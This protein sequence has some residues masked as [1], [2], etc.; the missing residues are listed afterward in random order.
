MSENEYLNPSLL[1]PILKDFVFPYLPTCPLFHDNFTD[2][3]KNVIKHLDKAKGKSDLEMARLR[4]NLYQ[5]Y[6][7]KIF[8]DHKIT[9]NQENIALALENNC[10]YY[11]ITTAAKAAGDNYQV[12]VKSLK[13]IE[14]ASV[15]FMKVVKGVDVP[16]TLISIGA[17]AFDE[18]IN[19]DYESEDDLKSFEENN[20]FK[21]VAAVEDGIEYFSEIQM[22]FAE[23]RLGK[24]LQ[25]GVKGPKQNS[26]LYSWVRGQA[27]V[28]AFKLN[29]EFIQ[30]SDNVSGRESFIK[31]SEDCMRPLHPDILETDAIRNVFEK[32]RQSGELDYL[33]KK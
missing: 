25:K 28:W 31:F 29:R 2:L 19:M 24:W 32:M 5:P 17:L 14:R 11:L 6:S 18:L 15:K 30:N 13:D 4:I 3:T 12:L 16:S 1:Y 22:H 10:V 26:A 23:T 9:D 27:E 33:Q 21:R 7:K 8:H 20:I